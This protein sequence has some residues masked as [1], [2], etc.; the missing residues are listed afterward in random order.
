MQGVNLEHH[1]KNC[2]MNASDWI[3]HLKLRPHP[4][5]GYFRETYRAGETI[6]A[7]ALPRRYNGSRA[8]STAILFLLKSGQVSHLHRLTSDELWHFY[9]GSPL[10]IHVFLDNGDYQPLRLHSSL[11]RS[12]MPQAVVPAGNWFG[13]TVDHPQSYAL[14]GCTV[15]PGFDF[16]DFELADR[17]LLQHID[18]RHRRLASRLIA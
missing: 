11:I 14:V 2:P 17:T 4:E 13:A 12:A 7:T 3:R 16:K 18:P 8:F 10:P 9:T 15:T 6:A 5:G 1:D